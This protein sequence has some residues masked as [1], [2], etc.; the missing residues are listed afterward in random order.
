MD[1]H[2][3][4]FSSCLEQR[5]MKIGIHACTQKI[6]LNHWVRKGDSSWKSISKTPPKAAKVA[7]RNIFAQ[8]CHGDSAQLTAMLVTS[9]CS[10]L[11]S[12]SQQSVAMQA[13]LPMT[14][15]SA[16][17]KTLDSVGSSFWL[18][19]SLWHAWQMVLLTFSRTWIAHKVISGI[20]TPESLL[21]KWMYKPHCP[22]Q[23]MHFNAQSMA[24]AQWHF[25]RDI[26]AET[27]ST[28]A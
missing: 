6:I 19:S 26:S 10:L 25:V 14:M 12:D 17:S 5:T 13:G 23:A 7:R 22:T 4:T 9:W 15:E 18:T 8:G 3:T 20:S 28:R 24:I 2:L 16:E 21:Q 27:L 11:S 1:K